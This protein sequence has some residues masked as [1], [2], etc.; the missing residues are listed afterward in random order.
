MRTEEELLQLRVAYAL[1]DP[2]AAYRK[3]KKL[4][5]V[6]RNVSSQT[7]RFDEKDLRRRIREAFVAL[8]AERSAVS[9]LE[10]ELDETRAKLESVR[11]SRTMKAGKVV[12]A[13][14]RWF[15]RVMPRKLAG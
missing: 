3:I 4:E 2:V 5:S 10:A 11:R 13:P 9:A 14:Y 12:S 8:E 7:A 1:R 15:K 6:A